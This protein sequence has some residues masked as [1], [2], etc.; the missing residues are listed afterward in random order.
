MQKLSVALQAE[1]HEKY[2]A[3][4]DEA[5]GELSGPATSAEDGTQDDSVLGEDGEA[6]PT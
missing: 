3:L 5:L 2:Q 4:I 1:T 6:Q